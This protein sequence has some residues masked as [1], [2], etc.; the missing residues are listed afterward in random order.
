ERCRVVWLA[1]PPAVA[2]ARIANESANR[3]VLGG[4]EPAARLAELLAA[5]E[6]L[7]RDTAH[8]TIDT[9]GLEVHEVAGAGLAA[10]ARAA[11]RP[12]PGRGRAGGGACESRPRSR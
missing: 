11:C 2:A 5:R 4:R 10:V 7:Y 9:A 1:V 8:V 6:A 12:P 3:P